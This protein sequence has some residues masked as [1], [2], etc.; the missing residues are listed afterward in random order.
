MFKPIFKYAAILLI[1]LV[2]FKSI[3]YAFFTH[4]I[5]LDLYLGIVALSFLAFGVFG[6]WW[7][8]RTFV[9]PLRNVKPEPDPDI[10]AKFSKRELEI[11]PLLSKGLTNKEIAKLLEISPNTIKT[12]LKNLYEKLESENRTQAVDEAKSLNLL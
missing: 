2:I 11:L 5:G 1:A 4:K 6:F 7:W 8:N 12:H 9:A 10:V 3:E